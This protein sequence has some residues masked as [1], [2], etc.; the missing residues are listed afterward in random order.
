MPGSSFTRWPWQKPQFAA[1]H[2]FHSHILHTVALIL[3]SRASLCQVLQFFVFLFYRISSS[4][5]RVFT[6]LLSIFI[7]VLSFPFL[8]KWPNYHSLLHLAAS[9]TL[10]FI[11]LPIKD[12]SNF[13]YIFSLLPPFIL[14]RPCNTS[15]NTHLHCLDPR[16]LCFIPSLWLT[17]MC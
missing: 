15:Q 7:V 16:S 8:S 13:Q 9:A 14:L 5:T 10:Q 6:P 11:P 17:C 12:V 2:T 4:H 1:F 3:L